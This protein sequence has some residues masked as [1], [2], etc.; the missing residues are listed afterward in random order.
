MKW[1]VDKWLKKRFIEFDV[2]RCHPKFNHCWHGLE[3]CFLQGVEVILAPGDARRSRIVCVQTISDCNLDDGT[4]AA[5][6]PDHMTIFD[7]AA[8]LSAVAALSGWIHGSGPIAVV[9]AELLI[10]DP[11]AT[12]SNVLAAFGR[13][14]RADRMAQW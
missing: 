10:G 12:G 9:V 5:A 13:D 2:F 14:Q 4:S 11:V 8:I 3:A 1:V 7:I 6:R